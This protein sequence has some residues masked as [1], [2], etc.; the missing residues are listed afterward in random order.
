MGGNLVATGASGFVADLGGAGGTIDVNLSAT[1]S[2]RSG[3]GIFFRGGSGADVINGANATAGGGLSNVTV[4]GDSGADSIP[5]DVHSGGAYSAVT[6]DGGSGADVMTAEVAADSNGGLFG[7][8]TGGRVS[9]DGGL[10]NDTMV[11]KVEQGG[12]ISAGVFDGGAG[13]DSITVSLLSGGSASVVQSGT[14]LIGGSGADTIAFSIGSFATTAGAVVR[15]GSGADVIT[16]TIGSG[17]TFTTELTADGGAGN[18]TIAFTFT[19]AATAGIV[20]RGI[21]QAA[22]GGSGGTLDG[23]AGAD[24]ITVIGEAVTGG[25][26]NFGNVKGG[27]GADTITVGGTFGGSGGEQAFFTGSIDGGAGADS[28]VFSGNNAYSG[29]VAVF[30]GAGAA[31]TGGFQFASGDSEIASF[32]TIFVSNNDV[33]GG[34]TTLQ[35]T[36]GSAG[37]NFSGMNAGTFTMATDSS[38]TLLVTPQLWVRPS[39]ET[40]ALVPVKSA[41]LVR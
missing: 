24:S 6:F 10:G 31:G 17:G 28:I 7:I 38:L 5:C 27:A 34:N 13:N 25:T 35:G 40:S 23:G 39:S 4:S 37:F 20:F 32:D 21:Q 33:T 15:A 19:A 18:D 9:F 12:G 26:F 22:N 36:F 30:V 41:A 8:V 16:G 11:L 14:E 29:G 2:A 3:G 1:M